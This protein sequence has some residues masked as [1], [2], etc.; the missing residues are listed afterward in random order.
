LE[1]AYGQSQQIMAGL[2][3]L[4]KSTALQ[5]YPREEIARLTGKAWL[6][7][8]D[9]K[10]DKSKFCT[11]DGR[12]LLVLAYQEM[13]DWGLNEHQCRQLLEMA[14][15]WIKHHKPTCEVITGD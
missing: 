1:S 12:H 11:P 8:L 4:I 14:R 2:P 10:C 9:S 15:E 3:A 6:E 7:M 13:S 5:A